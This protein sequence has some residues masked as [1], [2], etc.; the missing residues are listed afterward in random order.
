MSK[1]WW[2]AT[3][4]A[5]QRLH[6]KPWLQG[7]W[8]EK[9]GRGSTLL[10]GHRGAPR[11]TVEN[12]LESLQLALLNGADGVE[13]DVRLSADGVPLLM[14]DADLKRTHSCHA[15]LTDKTWQQW[16]QL[17]GDMPPLASLDEA[18]AIGTAHLNYIEIKDDTND[19]Q[20]W[21]AVLTQIERHRAQGRCVVASFNIAMALKF[22]AAQPQLCVGGIFANLERQTSL[23][24]YAP[25]DLLSLQQRLYSEKLRHAI[26][27]QGQLLFLWTVDAPAEQ[28]KWCKL[29]IDAIVA[30]QW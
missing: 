9:L 2:P 25:L 21:Q 27:S 11:L 7:C 3:E 17:K 6:D 15:Q 1:P 18:L 19:P 30:N 20:L 4:T 16:Q 23:A 26:E 22:K 10:F 28:A 8:Q 24:T 14:H 13:F 29:G 5:A 12:T